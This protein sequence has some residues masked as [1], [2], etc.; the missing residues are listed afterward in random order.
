MQHKS[1]SNFIFASRLWFA[2]IGTALFFIGERYGSSLHWLL[3]GSGLALQVVAI[4]V[5][6]M[7]RQAAAKAHHNE[8]TKSWLMPVLW[9]TGLLLACVSY[10]LYVKV[11]GTSAVPENWTQKVLLGVWSTLG[12]LSIFVAIGVEMAF[13]KVGRGLYCESK[14]VIRA[15]AAGL[16]VGLLLGGLVA[17][18]YA[19]SQRDKTYDWSY[20]KTSKP[21]DSTKEIVK[22]LANPV[23]VAVF[24][25]KNHEV[26]SFV[27]NYLS[28]IKSD[29][30]TTS[31]F[32]SEVQPTAAETFKVSKNGSVTLKSGDNLERIE[33]GTTLAGARKK[34]KNFDAEFQ[35]A[36]L[37]LT[38][39]KKNLYF[40]Q[41][42][43]ELNWEQGS[44]E[45]SADALRSIKLLE[46]VLRNQNYSLRRLSL[47]EGAAKAVPADASAVVVVGNSAPFLAEEVAAL[48]AYLENGG[49]LF[50]MLDMD[51]AGDGIISK[52]ARDIKKDPL[53]GLLNDF[54][55]EYRPIP[56]GNE[57][58]HVAATRSDADNWFIY[59]NNFASHESIA[60]LA[61][62][63]ERTALL[64]FRSGYLKLTPEKNGW[65]SS[66][67]IR[68]GEGTFADVNRDF[69]WSGADEEKAGHVVG[70]ALQQK[71]AKDGRKG[72]IVVMADASI[73]SDFLLR[74]PGNLVAVVESIHWLA[75]EAA[76]SAPSSEE[77]IKIRHT[78]KEDMAMFYGTVLVVP[79]LVLVAGAIGTRRRRRR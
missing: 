16:M 77:D 40:A 8:E 69:K 11:L 54:G 27:D 14:R 3:S 59:T 73:A 68:A 72:K 1:S 4:V 60:Q 15:G 44:S 52:L 37:A 28:Q 49:N 67:T 24:Y 65:Q 50:V 17:I 36:I 61:R 42:H 48:R 45:Q 71:N 13:A 10:L 31:F 46:G 53:V 7:G 39:Q 38:A 35:K 19:A 79:A 22:S 9:Q 62:A 56:L 32:D 41:G 63:D 34:L 21:S 74:N 5:A 75:G 55:V 58:E 57:T 33:L 25:P 76:R 12:L 6:I 43:G 18:N 51:P 29:K 2:V 66:E 78:N 30:L 26:I 23:E 70:S 64:L 20:L 47:A